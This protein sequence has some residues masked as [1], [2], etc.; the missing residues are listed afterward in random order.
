MEAAS[1]LFILYKRKAKDAFIILVFLDRCISSRCKLFYF[2]KASLY[3][4][5]SKTGILS[6]VFFFLFLLILSACL[7]HLSTDLSVAQCFVS[8]HE[9]SW[10][11]E[12]S[13]KL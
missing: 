11:T 9:R 13:D 10:K 3:I 12:P 1:F 7:D 8:M 2:T 6:A 5:R 4:S